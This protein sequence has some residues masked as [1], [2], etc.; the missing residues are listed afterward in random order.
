MSIQFHTKID[1]G[2]NDENKTEDA[3]NKN[4]KRYAFFIL[5]VLY[6]V[7]LIIQPQPVKAE[8]LPEEE[9]EFTPVVFGQI[10]SQTQ[11]V[12]VYSDGYEQVP[13]TLKISNGSHT[14]YKKTYKSRGVRIIEIPRQKAGTCLIFSLKTS[15]GKKGETVKKIVKDAGI[16]SKKKIS[17]VS[18]PKVSGKITD[19]STS[20]KVYAKKGTTLYVKHGSEILAKKKYKKS[21]YQNLPIK[22]QKAG[23]VITFFT[24]SKKGRSKYVEKLVTDVTAPIKPKVEVID[25]EIKVTGEV[26]TGVYV[27]D[28]SNKTGYI[29]W[30]F[31]K[32][33]EENE[34]V[35]DPW[36]YFG[37]EAEWNSDKYQVRLVDAWG[38]K[39]KCVT[40]Q[41][42]STFVIPE[43]TAVE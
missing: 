43:D 10:T 41:V 35:I 18:K 19:K 22:K 23:E 42:S 25:Y 7:I 15:Y 1:I 38:N 34:E 37:R 8:W 26:G 3:M 5:S 32:A 36:F 13:V 39:S 20:V 28:I 40:V 16:V 14:I 17:S 6:L 33:L 11:N 12:I 29:G 24:D 2:L 4:M 27:K 30:H 31:I 9:W 21:G